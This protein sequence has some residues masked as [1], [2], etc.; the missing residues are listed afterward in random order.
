M[1]YEG[2]L[3]HLKVSVFLCCSFWLVIIECP[4][5]LVLSS[6]TGQESE[7]P[8]RS[9]PCSTLRCPMRI[10]SERE[11]V[12]PKRVNWSRW[13]KFPFMKPWP[14]PSTRASRKRWAL[15]SASSGSTAT[16]HRSTRSQPTCN[17]TVPSHREI[18]V[19]AYIFIY[20]NQMVTNCYLFCYFLHFYL[21]VVV[22]AIVL[23]Q[24]EAALVCHP[25]KR[26]IVSLFCVTECFVFNMPGISASHLKSHHGP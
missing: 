20:S 7:W 12:N 5:S 2:K 18:Q 1:S 23:F 13:S 3:G 15:F 10:A 25:L 24:T 14:S 9:R 17:I 26:F 22:L 11:E 19:I 4:E 16:C 21:F 6:P 8:D